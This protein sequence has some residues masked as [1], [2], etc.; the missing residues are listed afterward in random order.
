MLNR[1][2]IR[3]KVMQLLFALK[4][5]A[6][7]DLKKD[8]KFLLQSIEGMYDLYLNML[9]L[10]IEIHKKSKDQLQK[11]KQKLLA[12]QEDKNPNEK[13]INNELL[14]NLSR[15]QALK[16]A[17][18]KYKI[19]TW[20]QHDEYV[21]LLFRDMLASDSY[22]E[23]MNTRV[24][25]FKEDQDFVVALYKTVIAPNEKLYEFI[26]DFKLTWLDDFPEINTIILKLFR[27]IKPSSPDTV[28]VP[29]L[30]KDEDDKQYAKDLFAKTILNKVSFTEE[31]SEKTKNWDSER[32]AKI[33]LVLLQ[34]AICEFKKFPSIPVKVTINEYLEIAKEYS[35]PKSS[36]F[37]NG[38]LDKLVREYKAE[39][40][41]NK[42][43]RG[44]M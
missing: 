10:L 32:I 26:E 1:R 18:E 15:S 37:I 29:R 16:E 4:N 28:F 5:G 23:Y 34:M 12:T 43:G 25:S 13:F 20:Q 31:I 36:V 27:K 44:L 8:E 40:A 19:T 14:N 9:S 39:G 42:V 33:D 3:V 38:I 35:T 7:D 41:L 2:H 22:K 6:S 21:D 17:F 11:N 24:S 30:Y